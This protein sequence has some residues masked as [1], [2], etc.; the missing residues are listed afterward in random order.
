[1]SKEE[2][3]IYAPAS[4]K[5]EMFLNSKTTITIAGGAAGCFDSDTEFLSESGWVKFSEYKNQ[6]VAQYNPE[7]DSISFVNPKEYIKEPSTGFKRVNT[8]YADIC[9]TEG[10]KTAYLDG[11][12]MK[13]IPWGAIIHAKDSIKPVIKTSFNTSELEVDAI[14]NE[15]TVRFLVGCGIYSKDLWKCSQKSIEYAV[16][17]ILY[18][19]SQDGVIRYYSHDKDLIDFVQ[20]ALHASGYL[21][22]ITSSGFEYKVLAHKSNSITL[23]LEKHE[24]SEYKSDGFMYCFEVPTGFLLVRR[25]NKVYISGNSG[26]SYTSLLIALKFMQHPRATGVIFRRTSKMLTAPGSL[27]QEAIAMYSDIYKTGLRIREGT[28]EIIFPNGAVLKFSHMQYENNKYDHKGGQ[29]SLVIFDEAT[30]F[31]ESQ[32]VYLLSRMR[33]AYVDYQPQ[34]FMMTN[35][36]YDSFIRTWIQDYYL[37]SDG[38]PVPERTGH[39]R[40]FFRQGDKMHWSNSEA[41]LKEQFGE[42]ISCTS[43]TFIGANCMDNPPLLKAD[44]TYKDRLLALPDVEVKRLFWGSWFA[45]PEAAG[46]WKREWCPIVQYPNTRARKRVRSW[47]IA[48]SLPS[49]AYPDPDWTRGVLVSKDETGVYTIEDLKSLR[50]RFQRVEELIFSTA[51]SDGIGTVVVLPADPNAQAGAWARGMQ[52]RLAE[53]GYTCRLVRPNLSKG[54]RFA[55]FSSIAQSGFMYVVDSDWYN[56]FCVELENFDPGNRKIKDDIVDACSDAIFILNK[57]TTLPNFSLPSLGNSSSNFG[58]Q[59]T[60]FSTGLSAKL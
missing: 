42:N 2:R 51:V 24:V 19:N 44:P 17:E 3:K 32:V 4:K 34:M 45:R 35:P 20:Y 49:P 56:D 26:K 21:T 46:L 40:Y 11:T 33:N 39:I 52:R 43:F 31:S 16:D 8:L 50:D 38:I 53:M 41:E 60:D 15:S 13:V 27:W 6:K 47:D 37:D 59:S 29:Y 5:Q 30:D 36:D 12:T 54:V 23:D 57:D 22:K 25:S 1:M 48:G 7:T 9:Q 28:N 10:H 18:S 14:L 55:P 58:L